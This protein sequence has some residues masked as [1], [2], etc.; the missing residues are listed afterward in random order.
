MRETRAKNFTLR[1]TETEYK[2]LCVEAEKFNLSAGAYL[3]RILYKEWKDE[4]YEV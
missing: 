1:L 2:K 3:R 4:Y